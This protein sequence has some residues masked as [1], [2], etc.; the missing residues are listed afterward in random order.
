MMILKMRVFSTR[1]LKKMISAVK[2]SKILNRIYVIHRQ[3]LPTT[4]WGILIRSL[5]LP[6]ISFDVRSYRKCATDIEINYYYANGH[7]TYNVRKMYAYAGA[8]NCG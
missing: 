8:K 7:K 4:I 1:F 2:M 5:N 6:Y 3:I